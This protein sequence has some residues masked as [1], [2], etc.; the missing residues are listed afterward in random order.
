[1][2]PILNLNFKTK[3]EENFQFRADNDAMHAFIPILVKCNQ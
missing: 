1:M 2:K 3:Y